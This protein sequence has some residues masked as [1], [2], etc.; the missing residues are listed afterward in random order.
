[1]VCAKRGSPIFAGYAVRDPRSANGIGAD[2]LDRC[3]SWADHESIL[4]GGGKFLGC[5][6]ISVCVTHAKP[7]LRPKMKAAE[8]V[9]SHSGSRLIATAWGLVVMV[10]RLRLS[11]TPQMFVRCPSNLYRRLR[12]RQPNPLCPQRSSIL[13]HQPNSDVS[14]LPLA[15]VRMLCI[16]W[17]ELWF[18]GAGVAG[19]AR[20]EIA[21]NGATGIPYISGTDACTK[22]IQIDTP[23][24]SA[25]GSNITCCSNGGFRHH[26]AELPAAPNRASSPSQD[27]QLSLD[28]ALRLYQRAIDTSRSPEARQAELGA[29]SRT[30]LAGC[31]RL[32]RT[33]SRSG[34]PS[35]TWFVKRS[36][37]CRRNFAW[38]PEASRATFPNS[39]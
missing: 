17:L 14:C 26:S 32:S 9:V 7:R 25:S 1:M 36:R 35:R 24:A 38:Q 10:L 34:R 27:N 13:E 16:G 15:G 11:G 6:I 5:R 31:I 4:D 22:P 30:C 20:T 18:W 3:D 8:H 29:R 19:A 23:S 33:K 28:D 39:L 21:R 2:P 37:T 12:M